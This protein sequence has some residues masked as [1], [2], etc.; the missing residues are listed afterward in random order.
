MNAEAR[1]PRAF[2]AGGGEMGALIR[3]HDWGA[4]PLGPPET[5][6]GPLRTSVRTML[7]T[8]HPVVLYWGRDHRILYNDAFRASLGP[9]THPRMLGL[10]GHEAWGEAWDLVGPEIAGVFAGGE[11]TWHENALVPILR[12]GGLQ[13]VYWTYSFGP[14]HDDAARGGIG[15]VIVLCTETTG[16]VLAD[17]R[18]RESEGRLAQLF[19]QA[20]TFMALLSG[21]EHRFERAN[22]GYMRLVG[23]RPVIGRTAAEAFPEVVAQGYIELLDRVY[24]TGEAY[25]ADGA[26]LT[27][28]ATPDAPPDERWVDFVYQPMRDAAGRVTGIFAE[29]AD[30]TERVRKDAALREAEARGRLL[31]TLGDRLRAL[32]DAHA[33]MVEAAALLGESLGAARVGYAEVDPE[34]AATVYRE[35]NPAGLPSLVGRHRLMD[36]GSARVTGLRAGRTDV[37]ADFATDPRLGPGDLAAHHA[38]GVH[39]QVVV[40]LV[41]AGRLSALLFVH[42]GTVRAWTPPE[43]RTIEEVAERTWGALERARA[44]AALRERDGRFRTLFGSLDAGFCVVEVRPA[45]GGRR[46]DYRVLEVNPAFSRHTGLGDMVGRWMREAVPGLEEHW[47]EIYGRV[48]E[49]GEAVRFEQGADA[50]GGRWFDV[51]AFRIGDPRLRQVAIFFTDISA[52]RRAETLLAESEARFRN[53]A[54]HAPVMMWMTEADGRCTYLNRSWYAFTGQREEEALGFGWLDATHPEDKAEAERVFL[55]ANAAG[56]AFRLEYRLRRADGAYRWC[57]DAAA[58]RHGD[59]GAF[60]GYVGSVLDI[61]ERREA[62]E[63]QS[64]LMREVDHRAKNALAMVQA[65]LRLTRAE[66]VA[67]YVRKIEGRVGALARA[68]TMLAEDRWVGADLRSVVRGELAPFVNEDADARAVLSG[69]DVMLSADGTQPVAMAVHELATNAVKH[70][71]L[72]VPGGRVSVTWSVEGSPPVLRLRWAESGG[73]PVAGPPVRQGFGSRVLDGTVR[74]Q[75]GG[76]ATLAWEASGLVCDIAVPLARGAAEAA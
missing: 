2:L 64:L 30:V 9:E 63:R 6:P 14:I 72:S 70:G 74:T 43:V 54:D 3:A 39:A 29:G 53:V 57:I 11:A 1:D 51:H 45:E 35:W 23:N 26:R 69:P 25:A 24:R 56:E 15:G 38:V 42:A 48:A 76:T 73:P 18:L 40:P 46:S 75:L 67:T 50:L 44:E 71:A 17:R 41:K 16:Q 4:T 47:F 12:H 31:V 68:Q 62:E 37:I 65:T 34:D 33:I 59:D 8:R 27:F 20:P 21:P 22:P 66:D 5:W 58:P 52:R 19:E 7:T 49:T 60:L 13:E 10:P 61:E 32:S 36:Y 28:R 55:R